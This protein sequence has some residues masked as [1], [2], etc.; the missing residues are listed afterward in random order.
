MSVIEMT[1]AQAVGFFARLPGAVHHQLERGGV[2]AA[3]SIAGRA[4]SKIGVMQPSW[5]PLSPRTLEDKARLG[6][7]GDGSPLLRTGEMRDSIGSRTT[8]DL[9]YSIG[10]DYKV[11]GTEVPLLQLHELGTK[12]MPPRPVLGP[13]A[14]EQRRE[15]QE[16]LGDALLKGLSG[17]R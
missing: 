8:G 12:N 11:S 13:A 17:A 5:A 10:S 4:R 16:I 15:V 7:S 2:K 3:A 14:I 1:L 6:Y 9:K